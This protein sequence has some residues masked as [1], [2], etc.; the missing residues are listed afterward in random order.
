M[1]RQSIAQI[2]QGYIGSQNWL[3]AVGMNKCNIFVYDVITQAGGTAPLDTSMRQRIKYY[4]GLANSPNYP[5]LAGDWANP[6]KTL[7]LWKTLTVPPG[8]Q[9]GA[10]PP[11]FSQ[12]GDV[13]A[14]AIQ[15]SDA[16][17]HVGIVASV[18]NTICGFCS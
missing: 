15:Y 9:T 11:D 8:A 14:E 1:I 12:P 3:D 17:G 7:G 6:N 16:T 18:G 4:L 2:A 13:I 10:R 5:A